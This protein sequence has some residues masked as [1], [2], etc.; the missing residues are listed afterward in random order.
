MKKTGLSLLRAR[1]HHF[2]TRLAAGVL[3]CALLVL[4]LSGC[5]LI[6]YGCRHTIRWNP[7]GDWVYEDLPNGYCLLGT[8]NVSVVLRGQNY[9]QDSMQEDVWTNIRVKTYISA[10]CNNDRYIAVRWTDPDEIDFDRIAEHDFST[11]KYVLVDS[12]ND[13]LYGPF[14]TEAEFAEQCE[15][16]E[17]GALSDWI[18]VQD[19]PEVLG[20]KYYD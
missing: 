6:L 19:M 15:T 13:C 1:P 7:F 9:I 11:A 2:R 3:L 17:V 4:A 10:V 5:R 16:L 14:D 18:D 8:N 12:T 20:D